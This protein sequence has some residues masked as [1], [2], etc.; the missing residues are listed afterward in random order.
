M[1]IVRLRWDGAPS[2]KAARSALRNGV[3]VEIELPLEMHH[4][5]YRH[6]HP[7]APRGPDE[8]IDASDSLEL[9]ARVATVAGLEELAELAP[10]VRRARCRVQLTGPEPRLTL[11]PPAPKRAR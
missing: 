5:L 7:D 3:R 9:L 10:A 8:E 4:A 6:V 11:V 2:I 1:D